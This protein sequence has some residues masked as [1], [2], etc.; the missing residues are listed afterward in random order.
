MERNPKPKLQHLLLQLILA[1]IFSHNVVPNLKL[2][3]A[4][5]LTKEN[6]TGQYLYSSDFSIINFV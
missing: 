6:Q 4:F 1:W 3:N 2:I 5:F